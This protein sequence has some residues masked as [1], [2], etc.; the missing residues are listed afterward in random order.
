MGCI[1][2]LNIPDI[3]L[4]LLVAFDALMDERNLT[5]AGARIGLSQPSMSHAL[6]R[7]RE[8]C[9]DPLFVRIRTG[10][11]PTPFAERIAPSVRD[12]LSMLKSGLQNAMAFDPAK[13]ERTFHLV[14]SDIGEMI[15]LPALVRR[16][17]ASAPRVSLRV[18]QLPRERYGNAFESGEVDLAIGFLPALQAGFYQQRLF[19]DTY[20]CIARADHP[21]IGARLTLEQFC[22]EDHVMVEPAGSRY[23]AVSIQ[24][25]TTTLIEHHLLAS[26]VSRRVALRV[27]H[28][29]VVPGLV[30]STDLVATLPSYIVHFLSGTHRLKQFPVPTEAPSFEVKQFWHQRNH[31]DPANRWLRKLVAELF[32]DA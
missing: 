3:D 18:I 25:S 32:L 11:Q 12:G 27:P 9:G 20:L 14:M 5:R 17:A 28:F 1:S 29:M 7:L 8:I 24:S 22:A 16:L 13:S 4:N 6:N 10:M 26:G 21:R 2:K 30:A 23:Q 15:Y 31:N 19:T